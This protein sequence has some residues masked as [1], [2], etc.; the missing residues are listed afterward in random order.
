MR[1]RIALA[2]A[3]LLAPLYLLAAPFF[4]DS[5]LT[6]GFNP[7]CRGTA[8]VSQQVGAGAVNGQDY[9]NAFGMDWDSVRTFHLMRPL[10]APLKVY[11]DVSTDGSPLYKPEYHAYAL[12]SLSAWN[13]ALG[14]RLHYT[15]TSDPGVADI[16]LGWVSAFPDRYVAGL[17][18]Y[19]VGHANIRIKTVGVPQSDIQAN[20]LHEFGHALG[21]A[22][23]SRNPAD[24]MVA[25]RKWRRDSVAYQPGL[26][27]QDIQAIRRLYSGDWRRGE[28]LYTTAAQSKP[29]VYVAENPSRDVPAQ[30]ATEMAVPADTK[31]VD[32]ASSVKGADADR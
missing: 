6:Q 24:I 14:G 31:A 8:Y 15:L 30:K 28:D 25:S 18:T 29:A 32:M 7:L 26:S 17:T 5:E 4:N 3:C 11:I 23:H 12:Q 16:T 21:I 27:K 9:E 10:S 22:G 13:E 20:I 19:R 1:R 2:G